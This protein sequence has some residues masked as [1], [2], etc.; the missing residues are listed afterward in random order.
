MDFQ[1]LST[2][3][4]FGLVSYKRED[5]G[6]QLVT[7]LYDKINK[8]A[9]QSNSLT[10]SDWKVK[11]TYVDSFT[12]LKIFD[13]Y[14]VIALQMLSETEMLTPAMFVYLDEY[15]IFTMY[16]LKKV[17]DVTGNGFLA[18]VK[19][20]IFKTSEDL[21]SLQSSQLG[22]K[23]SHQSYRFDMYDHYVAFS[24]PGQNTILVVDMI[25]DKVITK[26]TG[27]QNE[28]IGQRILKIGTI[29]PPKM[30]KKG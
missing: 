9:T 12:T 7:F 11:S 16:E 28:Q 5:S 6:L 19:F 20:D 22:L 10:L 29:E 24:Y 8:V 14:K 26:L 23:N 13:N 15:D 1:L 18:E 27:V 25:K 30:N 17:I 3:L 21:Y 2:D 4:N